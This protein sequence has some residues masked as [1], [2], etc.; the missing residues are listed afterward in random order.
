MKLVRLSYVFMNC[1]PQEKIL[2]TSG[3]SNECTYYRYKYFSHEE[4]D[5]D[6][7]KCSN[8]SQIFVSCRS[9]MCVKG[10]DMTS[11]SLYYK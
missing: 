10:R 4:D 5:D 11:L 2:N 3:I 9:S 7:D 1:R 6:Y 8:A